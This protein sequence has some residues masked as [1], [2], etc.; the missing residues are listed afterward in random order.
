MYFKMYLIFNNLFIIIFWNNINKL[1]T[2]DTNIKRAVNY[3]I[4]IPILILVVKLLKKEY[5]FVFNKKDFIKSLKVGMFMIV[6]SM[7]FPVMN[8]LTTE[9]TELNSIPYIVFNT[10]VVLIGTGFTEE[11][12]CRGILMNTFYDYFGKTRKTVI[13]CC[14]FVGIEFGLSHFVNIIGG[15]LNITQMLVTCGLGLVLCAIY[16][17]SKCLWGVIFLHG[18]WDV[19]I[20]SDGIIFLSNNISSPAPAVNT[21]ETLLYYSPLLIP[22]IICFLFL[23]RKSKIDECL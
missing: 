10:L 13:A 3:I 11:V 4:L 5:I 8:I 14:I 12:V 23:L 16:A 9:T 18:L 7:I 20:M 19:A 1:F 15:N 6:V 22:F 17:R 2:F 21:L